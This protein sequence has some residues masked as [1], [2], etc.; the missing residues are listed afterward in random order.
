MAKIKQSETIVV[1][2]SQIN[3]ASYNPRK[4]DPKVIEALKK[5]FKKV[6]FLGGIVWN[7]RSG[8]LVG[9]HKRVETLDI[10]H[11]Y[12]EET[13]ENDYEIKVEAID[14]DD[15]TEKEQNIFLNNKRVQGETDYEMLALIIPDIDI[16]STGLTDYDLKMVE[17]LVPDFEMGSNDFI[18]ENTKELKQDYEAKKEHVKNLKK[19]IQNNVKDIHS[20]S[21]F[22]VTFDTALRK[23]EFLERLGI[24]SDTIYITGDDFMDK[25]EEM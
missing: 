15:K 24:N 1:K 25:L 2:R 3:F 16:E 8:N 19:E 11:G 6:G 23:G 12:N 20:A 22:V 14:V 17:S 21:Y 9:G 4:K 18:L 13:K 5:N 7:Q 10:I